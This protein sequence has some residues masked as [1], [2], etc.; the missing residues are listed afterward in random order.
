MLLRESRE[1]RESRLAYGVSM[2]G[3]AACTARYFLQQAKRGL[4]CAL[5]FSFGTMRRDLKSDC[6]FTRLHVWHKV[7]LT[8]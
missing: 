4:R 8:I 2:L 5:R 6:L 3:R 1:S 7:R